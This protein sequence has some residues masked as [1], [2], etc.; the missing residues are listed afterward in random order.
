MFLAGRSHLGNDCSIFIDTIETIDEIDKYYHEKNERE[1]TQL[2][3]IPQKH[4]LV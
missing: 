4:T 2:Q 3:Q 1:Y